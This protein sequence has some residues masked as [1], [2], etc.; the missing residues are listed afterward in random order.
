MEIKLLEEQGRPEK[1]VQGQEH[2]VNLPQHMAEHIYMICF[3]ARAT[4]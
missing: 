2:G 3:Q 1:F 4:R